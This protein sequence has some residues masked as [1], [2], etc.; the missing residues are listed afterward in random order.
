[1]ELEKKV[2]LL[3]IVKLEQNKSGHQGV[4]AAQFANNDT[5]EIIKSSV[6]ASWVNNSGLSGR[7][8]RGA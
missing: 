8:S 6:W 3:L 4:I 7:G 1:M 2:S 5:D